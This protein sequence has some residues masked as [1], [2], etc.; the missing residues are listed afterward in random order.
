MTALLQ[1][2]QD[3]FLRS[4]PRPRRIRHRVDLRGSG[5]LPCRALE[6]M[7]SLYT[8]FDEPSLHWLVRTAD[9][10]V[11]QVISDNILDPVS[12]TEANPHT[13]AVQAATSDPD[14][15]NDPS[16]DDLLPRSYKDAINC[17]QA[18][19]WG[20]AIHKEASELIHNGTFRIMDRQKG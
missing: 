13:Y 19:Y 8:Y 20:A 18:S 11:L 2:P 1:L 12:R 17:K 14:I 5:N 3:Q 6:A 9:M 7:E 10:H 16:R 4:T 15:S